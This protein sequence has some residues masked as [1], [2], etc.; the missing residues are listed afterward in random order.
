MLEVTWEWT[1]ISVVAGTGY[2]VYRVCWVSGNGVGPYPG[3][4]SNTPVYWGSCDGLA[5]HPEGVV[6]L[7][8]A[9]F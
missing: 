9:Y 5:S 7:Q 2:L 4:T 3:M 1:A 8:V 6:M